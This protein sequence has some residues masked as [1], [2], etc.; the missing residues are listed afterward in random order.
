[1]V[2][3]EETNSDHLKGKIK[4]YSRNEAKKYNR[5][6]LMYGRLL[7]NDFMHF[8]HTQII[9]IDLNSTQHVYVSRFFIIDLSV[10][11]SKFPCANV[12]HESKIHKFNLIL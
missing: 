1:M 10:S 2:I 3:G 12:T 7:M 6:Q 9:G 8:T 11:R 5:E 4:Y